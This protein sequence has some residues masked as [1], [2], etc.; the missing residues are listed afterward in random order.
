MNACLSRGPDGEDCLTFLAL[1]LVQSIAGLVTPRYPF[2]GMNISY[3][4]PESQ[5]NCLSYVAK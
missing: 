2:Q 1:H 4:L 3:L 5:L